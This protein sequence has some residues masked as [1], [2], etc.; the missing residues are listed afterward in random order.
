MPTYALTEQFRR[1]YERLT[2]TE[3]EQFKRAVNKFIQDL[4]MRKFRASLRVKGIRGA[5]GIFELTW[6][7][8]GRAT[9]QYGDAI[10]EGEPHIVWRRCGGHEIFS[11]P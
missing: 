11:T 3:R 9:F 10:I 7:G 4:P 5:S 1:D 6:A 2:A 8:D